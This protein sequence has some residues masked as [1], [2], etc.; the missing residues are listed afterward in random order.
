[1]AVLPAATQEL[2]IVLALCT[3][4]A[5]GKF[6]VFCCRKRGC[7]AAERPKYNTKRTS[8][9]PGVACHMSLARFTVLAN[10]IS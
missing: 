7:V 3:E 2:M 9:L 10:V 1:M 6:Q 5:D 4:G 8:K